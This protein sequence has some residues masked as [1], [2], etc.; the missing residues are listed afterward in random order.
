MSLNFD[1][2]EKKLWTPDREVP[3]GTD[4][5]TRPIDPREMQIIAAMDLVGKKYGI[6]LACETCRHPF[7][8]FNSGNA[9]T[10]AITCGCRELKATMRTNRVSL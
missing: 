5:T 10:V 3:I 1:V 7:Q 9:A 8:G 2:G 4:R 6:V